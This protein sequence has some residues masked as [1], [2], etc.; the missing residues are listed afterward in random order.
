MPVKNL[1]EAFNN[2]ANGAAICSQA[3]LEHGRPNE[4]AGKEAQRLS[5]EGR[6]STGTPFV[7]Q[8]AW[9]RCDADLDAAVKVVVAK[10]L[11]TA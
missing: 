2:A 8:S 4:M 3:Y 5:F 9:M 1:T 10:M 6:Y 11:E 7:V